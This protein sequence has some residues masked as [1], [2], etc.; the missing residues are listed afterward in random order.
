MGE[1][2]GSNTAL[3]HRTLQL[4]A[5]CSWAV[6]RCP[7]DDAGLG[8]IGRLEAGGRDTLGEDAGVNPVSP[9]RTLASLP[10]PLPRTERGL[11]MDD[12]VEGG[13]PRRV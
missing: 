1:G 8:A 10:P 7:A 13:V 6:Y 4:P 3:R 9:L 2:V 12:S 5:R 11:D